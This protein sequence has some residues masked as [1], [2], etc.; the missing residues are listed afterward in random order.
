VTSGE[1]LSRFQGLKAVVIGDLMLDEYIF[2]KA[3]RISPEAPV[4]VI[5]QTS[6]DRLPGGAANVARN[7]Q[8]LGAETRVL[9]VIGCDEAGEHLRQ[10]LRDQ[11]LEA[12]RLVSDPS[13]PTTRKTRIVADH[14]HQVL[15]IDH[16][17]EAAVPDSVEQMMCEAAVDMI[18][19]ANVVVLSDYLKGALTPVIAAAVLASAKSRGIPVVVNPKPRSMPLY[20]GAALV[21][22][23]RSE[24][25]EVLS[26]WKGLPDDQAL[27]A[28][29]QILEN[30]DLASVLVTLGE[31]GMIAVGSSD[32]RVD[33]PRVEVY[34]TA[35]AG[36]T[37]IATVALGLA[38]VGFE[39]AVFELAAQ[40]AAS[41]V[42]HVG[43]ATP[44]K[45]DLA[46][47]RG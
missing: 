2:G 35:G 42:K 26:L 5:R 29:R 40:T 37:V 41:V 18:E 33:A 10:S 38:A 9:G 36:D 15:R 13:R 32:V 21:S 12:E 44:S 3:A 24:A 19:G 45:E 31:S 20:S 43:V 7:L 16:E 8:A 34:D 28:A 23:N 46:R 27:E 11:G 1:L 6:T 14:S 17:N 4:M 39:K 47:M 25:A 30:F 22:L